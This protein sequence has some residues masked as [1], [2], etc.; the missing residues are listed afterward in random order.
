[1]HTRK[2]GESVQKWHT[3]PSCD[4]KERIEETTQ[5][6]IAA[7]WHISVAAFPAV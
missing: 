2:Q 3:K 7:C 6:I 4:M 5:T 1:M